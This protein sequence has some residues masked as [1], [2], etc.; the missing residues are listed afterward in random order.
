MQ[1]NKFMPLNIM[2]A[3][4]SNDVLHN[5]F[6]MLLHNAYVRNSWPTDQ[7]GR[8]TMPIFSVLQHLT[9]SWLSIGQ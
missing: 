1:D 3:K 2:T 8:S 4:V 5:S 7:H 9:V 6:C